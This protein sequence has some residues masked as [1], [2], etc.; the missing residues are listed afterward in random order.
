[1]ADRD[2]RVARRIR[3]RD[4]HTLRVVAD[5][6]SMARAAESLAL[7]QPA[8]SK[9]VAE[10]ERALGVPLLDRSARGV[11]ATNYGRVLL[12]R[13]TT[14]LDELRQG[15]EEIRFLADPTGGE[16]R[17]G[18]TEPM[19]AVVSA[20]IDRLSG[21]HPRMRFR[22]DVAPTKELLEGLRGRT[23][24]LAVTR[25]AEARAEP[26]LR[27]EVLFEDPLAVGV[28]RSSSR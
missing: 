2:D 10:M 28:S 21:C 22:V 5:L 9:A 23:L 18:A 19:T 20:V 11:A 17:V 12:A 16:V 8:I 14:M 15:I 13:G 26:D 6:G 1:M 3:L 25:M 27:V 24:D 7:S 4:L